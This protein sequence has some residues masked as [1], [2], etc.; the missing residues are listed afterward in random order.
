VG[1]FASFLSQ[2][3]KI[4]F[5]VSKSEGIRNV[6]YAYRFRKRNDAVY[7]KLSQLVCACRSYSLPKLACF[8]DTVYIPRLCS[9][10]SS[11]TRKMT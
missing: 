5:K 3:F 8:L 2:L 1:D 10:L 11:L 9:V 6:E 7:T 4:K